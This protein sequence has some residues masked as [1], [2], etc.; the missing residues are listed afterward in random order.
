MAGD[1]K[2]QLELTAKT[3]QLQLSEKA[4]T[5]ILASQAD[6]IFDL[7]GDKPNEKPWRYQYQADTLVAHIKANNDAQIKTL[8]RYKTMPVSADGLWQANGDY[9]FDVELDKAKATVQG[10]LRDSVFNITGKLT[11]P[12]LKPLTTLLNE[13]EVP[14][15]RG[16][17]SIG[18]LVKGDS[19]DLSQLDLLLYNGDSKLHVNGSIMDLSNLDG[20]S[21]T[22]SV[23]AKQVS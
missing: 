15:D 5:D 8:G 2:Q 4:I 1:K 20:L 16:E 10:Y 12:S 17:L 23:A 7:V 19:V 18:I 3:L 9:K 21:F 6:I 13:D 14:I 22:V 11:T